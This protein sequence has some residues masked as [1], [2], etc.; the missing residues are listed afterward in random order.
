M[1]RLGTTYMDT[2]MENTNAIPD[3]MPGRVKGRVTRRKRWSGA[4]PS[5][6]AA[7]GSRGS[8]SRITA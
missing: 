8:R 3:T 4:A 2:A 6:A 7:S 1:T 5:V